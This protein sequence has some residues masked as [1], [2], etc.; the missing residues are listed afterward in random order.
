MSK[1]CFPASLFDPIMTQNEAIYMEDITQFLKQPSY[2]SGQEL[3]ERLKGKTGGGLLDLAITNDYY[4]VVDVCLN[5]LY[6]PVTD[7][8]LM[9]AIQKGSPKMLKMLLEK[10]KD[11]IQSKYRIG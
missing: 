6:L 2:R 3:N 11:T 4:E 1:S 5:N 8:L 9:S 10:R 7:K